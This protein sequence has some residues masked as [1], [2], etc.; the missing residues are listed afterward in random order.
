MPAGAPSVPLSKIQAVLSGPNGEKLTVEAKFIDGVATLEFDV[1]IT[2]ASATFQLQYTAFDLQGVVAFS[3]TQTLTLRPGKNASVPAPTLVYDAPDAKVTTLR[4][5]PGSVTLQAGASGTLTIAG[6]LANGQTLVPRVAWTSSNPAVVAVNADGV[7][8]AGRSQGTAT[9][10][11]TSATGL[12]ATAQVKVQAP[13]DKVTISPATATVVRGQTQNTTLDIRDATNAV[14]DDRT[15]VYASADSSIATI[16]PTGVITGVKV[17]KTTL[18]VTAEGKTATLPVTIIS[19]LDHIDLTSNAIAFTSLKA[20]TT[21]SPK[22][23]PVTGAS[24][25]GIVPNYSSSNPGVASVDDKGVVTANGNGTARITISFEGVTTVADVTVNQVAQ[26]VVISPRTA[27]V[28][29]IGDARTFTTAIVDAGNSPIT[30]PTVVWTSSDPTIATVAGNGAT[31]TVTAL[32]PGTVTI[33]ASA[34]GKTDVVTFIVAPVGQFLAVTASKVSILVGQTATAS[35]YLADANGNPV[36]GANATFTTTTPNVISISGNVITGLSAGK[37]HIVATAGNLSGA[38]DITVTAPAGGGGGGNNGLTLTPDSVEKLPGGTQQFAVAGGAGTYSWTVNGIQNGNS[39]YGTITTGGFYTAPGAVPSP[40]KFQVC[41]SQATPT[42]LS[43]CAIVVISPIPSGGADVI[44]INDMNLMQDNYM[45]AGN[46]QFFKNVVG[47]TPVGPRSTATKVMFYFGHQSQCYPGSCGP[48]ANG[49]LRAD[50]STVGITQIVDDVSATI[51]AVDPGVKVL[52]LMNPK[53]TFSKTEV[54]NLK[55]F[56]GEG[57]RIVFIGENPGYYGSGIQIE[58]QLLLDLGA[59]LTN[60]TG[61]A[62]CS[63][64][65]DQPAANIRTHQTTTGVTDLNVPCA[66]E[67]LLG[68]NDYAIVVGPQGTARPGPGV[69]LVPVV[70]VAKIDLTP[71]PGPNGGGSLTTRRP[72][73][74]QKAPKPASTNP[75]A[76]VLFPPG[77]DPTSSTGWP[78]KKP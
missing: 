40:S 22:L 54:N 34:N 76:T 7:L 11:A 63:G 75:N 50:M 72:V 73:A 78:T 52:Y 62:S 45:T 71:L 13:V 15:P 37:G 8:A 39:T 69:P 35:A 65:D 53:S 26:A 64:A 33:T 61:Y 51:T 56:A 9:I 48:S 4:I 31:V 20:T 10:T 74:P 49:A 5:T 59:Q 12:T 23:I 57:G 30:Q 58:N 24:V 68:P 25:A 27:S 2:G 21:L 46:H 70:A 18:T 66:T 38:V 60:S 41:A 55:A 42:A 17:G 28:S 44:V 19:P 47:F 36:G 6:T 3:A 67:I 14:I 32:R 1:P 29:A 16:S 77:F 43:G